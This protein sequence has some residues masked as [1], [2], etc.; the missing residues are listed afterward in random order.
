MCEEMIALYKNM[1]WELVD[2]PLGK[3]LVGCKWVYTIKYKVDESIERYK[4][5]L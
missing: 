4:A 5:R 2:L 1:T 3:Q